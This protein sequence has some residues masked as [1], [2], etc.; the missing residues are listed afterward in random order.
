MS[1][2]DF[3]QHSAAMAARAIAA[4][5][6]GELDGLLEPLSQAERRDV[7]DMLDAVAR[8][9]AL[10]S[11][12]AHGMRQRLDAMIA[13]LIGVADAIDGDCDLE[14]YLTGYHNPGTPD[15]VEPDGDDEHNTAPERH[16]RGFVL[17]AMFSQ[18][19]DEP[20]DTGIADRDGW[21]EQRGRFV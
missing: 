2:V 15:E 5:L 4:L 19:G 6:H 13:A 18:D 3:T 11:D 14:P 9:L 8:N 7:R 10:R 12:N 17:P 20:G 16:G 1:V 21:Q